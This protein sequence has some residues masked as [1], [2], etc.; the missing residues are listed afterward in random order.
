MMIEGTVTRTGLQVWAARDAARRRLPASEAAAH[1][2]GHLDHALR[3]ASGGME[4]LAAED[5]ARGMPTRVAVMR[6][7]TQGWWPRSARGGAWSDPPAHLSSS[8]IF[9]GAHVEKPKY[10]YGTEAI[11]HMALYIMGRGM[12]L[13]RARGGVN[14]GAISPPSVACPVGVRW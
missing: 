4:T 13:I 2:Q 1:V 5:G 11:E 14:A 9:G 12:V 8:I 10:L 3:L 7:A 6:W